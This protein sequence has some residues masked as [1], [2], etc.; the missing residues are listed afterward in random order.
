MNRK[1]R[2]AAAKSGQIASKQHREAAALF[3]A[4]VNHHEAGRLREAEAC[5]RHVLSAC[6]DHA[7]ALH[8]LGLIAFQAGRADISAE[9]IGKAIKLDK[10]NPYYFFNLGSAL[11]ALRRFDGALESYDNALALKPDIA[12]ALNNR[13]NALLELKRFE[14][15]LESYDKALAVRPGYAEAF[16]NRGNTLRELNRFGEAL[17]SYERALALKPD[18]AEAFNG[19]GNALQQLKRLDEA[20]E[21]YDKALALNPGSADTFYNRGNALLELKQF[22]EALASYDSALALKPDHA[23]AFNNRG[24]AL[25]ELKRFEEALECF[26]RALALKPDYAP[27][28]NNLGF[29]LKSLKRFGEALASYN[30]ALALKPDYAEAFN[31]RGDALRNLERFGEALASYEAGIALKP[32]SADGLSGAMWCANSLCDWSRR[33]A[34]SARAA[35]LISNGGGY[36]SPFALLGYCGDPLLQLKCAESF[37]ARAFPSLPRPLW[38]GGAWRRDKL[39]IAYLSADFQQHATAHLMAELFEQHDRSRFEVIAVDFSVDDRSETRKRLVAAFDRWIDVRRVSDEGAAKL[40]YDLRADIAIDLKGHTQ[41]SRPGILSHRPA[42]VQVSYL[43]YPGATGL[44]FI[45]YIIADKIVAPLECQPFF[46]EKIV[47]LPD[48]Y[49]VN[50]AKRPIAGQT[51]TRAEAGLPEEG[52]VFCCFN[53]NW[54]IAPDRFGVWMRLLAA[55]PAS[56]LWLLRDNEGA[57]RNLRNEARASGIDPARLIFASRLPFEQ[58]LARHRLA[59]L[60]LDTLPCNAHTTASDALWAGVPVVT[61]L[62]EAFAGRVAASL[63]HAIGLPE[64]VTR[65]IA[66]YEALALRLARDPIALEGYKNRLGAN[67]L[68]Y[69]LFDT[70]RFRR[71]IEAAYLQMWKIGQR[72]ES[73]RSFEVEAQGV[74]A[75]R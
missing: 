31:G 15:A 6:P 57:E 28:F 54:K 12:E 74:C 19:R 43:G 69:P 16:Y 49:Q 17:A 72:G 40:L 65:N 18:S 26:S 48:C 35:E 66:D 5:Y 42:P 70:D 44:P 52:F 8:L 9:L 13:G 34:L 60:F 63:L 68:T 67:R 59:D 24:N 61:Q 25:L 37:A 56:V 50:D 71:H 29:A 7:D 73:P 36:V 64:L 45:D 33:A 20:L 3:E 11:Q 47:H 32:D 4:G 27:A 46:T 2:R 30:R 1:Q 41:D 53:G 51:P 38:S 14:K 21:S 22:E 55:V 23:L 75:P 62:G 39:R 58:H 10:R